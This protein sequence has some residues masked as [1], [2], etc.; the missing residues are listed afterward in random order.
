MSARTSWNFTPDEFAWVWESETG[1][2]APPFPISILE[3]HTTTTEHVRYRAAV[4]ARYPRHADPD[5]TAPLRALA[6]PDLRIV[7]WGR[8]HHSDVRLRAL[9][10]VSGPLGVVLSQKPG[11]AADSGGDLRLVV[12]GPGHLGGHLAAG[13]PPAA[14]GAAGTM[15]GTT[16]G[17]RGEEQTR[18]DAAQR[19]IEE[20][21]RVLLRAP[22]SAE[23]YLRIERGAARPVEHLSWF[24]VLPDTRVGGRYLVDV[25][26]AETTITAVSAEELAA[27]IT[28]RAGMAG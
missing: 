10:A 21:M 12:T 7:S 13:L 28:R 16:P 23:G 4:S 19:P 26:D 22:R 6:D 2:D 20:R 11:T 1:E 18:D 8:L 5:L 15:T 9:G 27:Q 25:G 14:A 17:V 24:D 3:S